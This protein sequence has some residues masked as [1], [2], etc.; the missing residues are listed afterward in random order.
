M[1]PFFI[2]MLNIMKKK[3]VFDFRFAKNGIYGQ[4][5]LSQLYQM[6]NIKSIYKKGLIQV[7]DE[8]DEM[9]LE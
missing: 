8:M 1:S 3:N 9:A 6:L 2:N 7:H 5:K 4:V